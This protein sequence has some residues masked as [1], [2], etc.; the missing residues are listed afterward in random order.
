MAVTFIHNTADSS[1]KRGEIVE[2]VD[3]IIQQHLRHFRYRAELVADKKKGRERRKKGKL[4]MFGG[5]DGAD[6]G[7]CW[8][9]R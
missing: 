7:G 4:T 6:D 3:D 9:W 2:G 5:S 1:K 8:W